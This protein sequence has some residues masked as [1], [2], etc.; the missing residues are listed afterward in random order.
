MSKRVDQKAAA[1][2]VREH[3]AREQRR[4]RLLWT[5]IA[6]VLAVVVAGGVGFGIWQAQQPEKYNVPATATAKHDGM[7]VTHNDGKPTV[8]LYLDY[9]CP[10]CK[11]VEELLK[12]TLDQWI[13]DKTVTLVYHP[14]SIL[15]RYSQPNKFS[16]RAAGAAGCAADGGKLYEFSNALFVKQPAENTGGLPD[17]EIIAAGTSVGLTDPAFAQCVR[18]GKYHTWAKKITTDA[19]KRGVNGTPTIYVNDKKIGL[20]AKIVEDLK[21]EVENAAR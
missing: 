15:D 5:S 1:R 8:E 4:R 18:D 13:A 14:I 16:T 11:Q 17:E 2:V 6:V 20:S 10:L 3:I 19:T 9:Q 21:K 7:F 12:P